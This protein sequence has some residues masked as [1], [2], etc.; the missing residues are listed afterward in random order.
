MTAFD[1]MAPHERVSGATAGLAREDNTLAPRRSGADV[2]RGHDWRMVRPMTDIEVRDFRFPIDDAPRDWHPAGRAVTAYWDE[3]SIFFPK[4]ETFFVKSV[5]H[6]APQLTDQ[7]LKND[8][9]AFCAQEGFHGREHVAYNDRLAR[10][11]LPI[12]ALEKNVERILGLA[13]KVLNPRKQLAVTAALEHFTSLMG[14][15]ILGRPDVLEGAHPAMTGLWR[16]H[17]AEENEHR[18]VAFDVYQAVGGTWF[19][20]SR[21]MV[22][23]TFFFWNMVALNTVVFMFK[24]GDLLNFREWW[25]LFRFQ[26]V[27]PSGLGSL[28]RPYLSYFARDF[29]P[30]NRGGGELIESWKRTLKAA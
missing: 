6:F 2:S 24:R 13:T 7:Q 28:V 30:A 16:W 17:A 27:E 3:L 9:A 19:E 29:H 5:R 21:I 18:S 14:E 26:W 25:K 15:F 22:L 12:A 10:F 23:V 8:V 4:G 1:M 11:G 20:R